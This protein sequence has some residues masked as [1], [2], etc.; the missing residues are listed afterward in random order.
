MFKQ[1]LISGI[2]LVLIIAGTLYMG[3]DVTLFVMGVV[4]LIGMYELY[5]IYG[6]E[7]C[8]LSYMAYLMAILYYAMIGIGY[9][10]GFLMMASVLLILL[11][12]LYVFRYPKYSAEQAMSAFFGVFYVAV[13]MSFVYQLRVLENGGYLVVLIFLSSWGCDT[14]AYCT[15]MLIGKH[16]MSPVLSPKKTIEGAVGG[17]IGA[18]ILGLLY[19]MLIQNHVH[20]GYNVLFVFPVVCTG[21]ALL[22]MIGD[23]CASAIKRNHNM[24]DYGKLIP[25][26]GGILDRFDSMIFTAPTIFYLMIFLTKGTLLNVIR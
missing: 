3:G 16:K 15:G 9:R 21:G 17:V 5:R 7:K 20:F 13:M 26:H 11:M 23:L 6:I 4:S 19:G 8:G 22:S 18:M 12:I 1:R 24:K 14:L 2:I 10:E 25:G